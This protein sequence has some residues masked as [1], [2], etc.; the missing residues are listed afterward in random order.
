MSGR[1]GVPVRSDREEQDAERPR[2]ELGDDER[3]QPVAQP[4][5]GA[6]RGA[7]GV[8]RRQ[9]CDARSAGTS[10]PGERDAQPEHECQQ[11]PERRERQADHQR[12]ARRGEEADHAGCQDDAEH[13]AEQAA[14]DAERQP[15][16]QDDAEHLARGGAGGPQQAELARALPDRHGQ[17]VADQE[18]ADH[19]GH[20]AE[21]EGHAAEARLGRREPFRRIVRGLDD[22]RLVEALGDRARRR[23]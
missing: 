21:Q 23:R 2:H 1:S 18:R 10:A 8:D 6:G 17:R 19:H 13:D 22:E 14:R 9:A 16:A 15:L 11:Q 7:Q 5:H 12:R 4:H 3:A 20:Q